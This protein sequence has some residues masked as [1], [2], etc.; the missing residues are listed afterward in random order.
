MPGK[1]RRKRGKQ[2]PAGKARSRQRPAIT[3]LAS[4][5]TP[6]PADAQEST[7][8]TP[9]IASREPIVSQ[10]RHPFIASELRTIGILAGIILI[11]LIIL[12]VV[13]P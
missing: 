2:Q 9:V 10:I 4:V 1:A 11:I 12:Y 5:S 3:S 6:G 7:P 8:V 13:L